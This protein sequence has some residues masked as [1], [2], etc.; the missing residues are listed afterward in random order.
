MEFEIELYQNELTT[1]GEV[2][3]LS[4]TD[5]DV[6]C[7]DC[8]QSVVLCKEME[9]FSAYKLKNVGQARGYL[10]KPAK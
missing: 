2:E 3:E 5:A 10:D 7:C 1:I 9:L 4:D 8:G 6:V